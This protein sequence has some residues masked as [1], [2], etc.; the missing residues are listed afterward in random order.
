MEPYGNGRIH[1]MITLF[2]KGALMSISNIIA[3]HLSLDHEYEPYGGTVT[4]AKVEPKPVGF[5]LWEAWMLVSNLIAIQ[6]NIRQNIS[7][8]TKVVDW[9]DSSEN[10]DPQSGL[11][12]TMCH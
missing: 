8:S 9:L 4:K 7:V 5:I 2:L 3:I 11:W 12:I 1:K 10:I 6:H